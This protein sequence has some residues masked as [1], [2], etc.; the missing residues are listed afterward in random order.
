M[1]EL[2]TL[3]NFKRNEDGTVAVSGRELHKGLEIETPYKQWMNRMIDYGF[4]ENTDYILVFEKRVT[5][6]PRNPYTTQTDHIM[7]LDMSKAICSRQ[8]TKGTQG[9]IYK[10]LLSISGSDKEV[11]HLKEIRKE[12]KFSKMLK[13]LTGIQWVEQYPI[14][15]GKYRLDFY[16]ESGLIVEYDEEY[17]KY[18]TSKDIE[19]M[20]YCLNWIGEQ[21]LLKDGEHYSPA[22]IR[23]EEGKELEGLKRILDY[24][25]MND[26]G[27][28]LKESPYPDI[29]PRFDG[30]ERNEQTTKQTEAFFEKLFGG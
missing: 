24:L 22:V 11:V 28:F 23:V 5:N 1:N 12:F 25:Y 13:T 10:Y 18:Q 8:E 16:N 15:G 21:N 30:V 2:Q 4:E 19:R 3:F 26:M 17:H 7:T 27:E 29:N 20:E 9:K 14:D 6:N